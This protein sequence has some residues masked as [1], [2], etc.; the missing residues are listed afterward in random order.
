MARR[1]KRE[2]DRHVSAVTRGCSLFLG[3]ALALATIG[4]TPAQTP[5]QKGTSTPD[6]VT[7]GFDVL[8]GSWVRPDGGY[9]IAIKGVAPSGELDAMYFNPNPLPF[10]KARASREG[11]TLR[12]SFEL[13]AGGYNGSTYELAYDPSSDRLKGI[14]YQAVAKQKYEIYFVRK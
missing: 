2:G 6:A 9:T 4:A 5:A 14:Y 13:S 7:A 12:V 8:K 1:A 3:L 10:A 11:G